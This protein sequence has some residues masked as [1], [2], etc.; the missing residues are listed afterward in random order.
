MT[1]QVCADN[2]QFHHGGELGELIRR[3]DW[4][5]SGLGAPEKWP[6]SLKT[7]TAMLLASPVPI[8]LL[9]GEKGIMIY[10]DAYSGF[11][12]DRHPRL[13]GSEV[14][15]GWAEVAD[16]NDHVMRVG[17]AGKTLAYKDQELT[18]HRHGHP[19]QVWMDLD[20]SPVPDESGNPAGVIAIVV[21][22]TERVLGGRNLLHSEQRFR[23]L[24]NATA[25]ATY[26][27]S[28]N[29]HILQ[30]Q[31]GLGVRHPGTG[32][33][34]S[35]LQTY[36]QPAH[37]PRVSADIEQAIRDKASFT[38]EHPI[39]RSDGSTG[40]ALSRAVPLF[41]ERGDI[42]EWFGTATDITARREAQETL[43]ANE[44]RLQFLDALNKETARSIDA[45]VI[46]AI[47]TQMLGEHLE[48]AV[49]AYADM[50]PDQD[51]FTIRG[52][53]HASGSL[54]IVGRY[55]LATFG[56]LALK[57]LH[58][59]LPLI[60]DETAEQL[61]PEEAEAFLSI[62]L[63]STICMPLV[64]D[65]RLTAL[66][67]IHDRVARRW[68][69]RELSLLAEVTERSWAHI[70]RVRAEVRRRESE[71]RFRRD[72]EARVAE[73]TEAL[74][75]SEANIR[76]TEQALQQAQKMEAL[77]NL[78]G[79]I[80][81]DFNNLLM[82]VLGSLDLLRRRLPDSPQLLKLVDNAR[83]GAERGATLIARM[84]AFARRQELR[85]EAVE[86]GQLVA[87]MSELLQRSLGPTIELQ[88]VTAPVPAW[89]STD[90]N[91]LEAALLN[92]AVNARDAM[93]GQGLIVIKAGLRNVTASNLRPG[94]GDYWCLSVTDTG[95][96]MDEETLKRA[97][98]PF[99]TTKGVGQGTGLGL[100]MV[101]GLVEQC[102]GTLQ[103]HSIRGVGTT[104]E[105]WL[106]VTSAPEPSLGD[107][108]EQTPQSKVGHPCLDILTVD[109]DALVL[110]STVEMLKDM[111]HR[112]RPA[113]SARAALDYLEQ[114]HFDL[115]ITDHAMPHMTG[116]QLVTRVR[117]QHPDMPVIL[118]SGYAEAVPGQTVEVP[119]LAKPF[120]QAQLMEM[121]N[122]VARP[123]DASAQCQ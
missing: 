83:S 91:Q 2:L 51:G 112:V 6:Q 47:T 58:A 117:E 41:D 15:K 123:S 1:Q 72:L 73:R 89:V 35:W 5:S 76:R 18:L 19:E 84:L 90:P 28:Q 105:M 25:D 93:G 12:G 56:K 61:A 3:H 78:T 54:G 106:P 22:T 80:A 7:I 31:D 24:V 87:G 97:T 17:L 95:E 113:N 108:V 65:G 36:I 118:V 26:R 37:Q 49:C 104:A 55:S 114:Q 46:M 43:R 70:E 57:R 13:L 68:T 27:L 107:S 74:R 99:F 60:L 62:G 115:I 96:G 4:T 50:E 39:I 71:E 122:E 92:L 86:L 44:R 30:H 10:N 81:H 8:V 40:W 88:I 29:W 69:S 66:M 20:Y 14:R 59:G 101:H 34:D 48:V 116:A 42:V 52:D 100:S 94:P 21:E 75:E 32:A 64:K 102:G 11:A 9:W 103:L 77:G 16:F 45:N 79:G 38:L 121:V 23:A 53:W 120:S 109:D 85:A 63:A 119:R 33:G 67:S 111:G 98:E 110:T 82:A